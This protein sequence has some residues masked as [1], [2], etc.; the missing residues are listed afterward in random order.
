MA[1]DRQAR[2]DLRNALVGY[3]AGTIRTFAFDD[4]NSACRKSADRSVQDVSRE[5][6]CIHDDFEDHPISVTSQGW[7]VLRRVVAFLG[8]DLEIRTPRHKPSWPFHD[9][10][11]WHAY[12]YLVNE[13]GVPDYDPAVHARPANRWWNRVPSSIGFL[14]L[15][16]LT[17]AVIAALVLS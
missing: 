12:E 8:T 9:E 17:A 2:S 4:Q 13:I 10:E 14:L 15:G 7:E 1:I 3:M 6:Y 11:Q 16:G 5:L